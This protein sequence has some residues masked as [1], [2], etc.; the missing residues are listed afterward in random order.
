MPGGESRL[1]PP[2]CTRRRR[3]QSRPF[4]VRQIFAV[5]GL[6]RRS[7]VLAVFAASALAAVSARAADICESP[8]IRV[9]GKWKDPEGYTWAAP[10]QFESDGYQTELG[11]IETEGGYQMET[12]A[13][14]SCRGN[15]CE[16][17][18]GEIRVSIGYSSGRI[19]LN[20]DLKGNACHQVEVYLHELKHAAFWVEAENWGIAETRKRLTQALGVLVPVRTTRAGSE[21]TSSRFSREVQEITKRV[22]R[23]MDDWA[24]SRHRVLDSPENYARE[25][26]QANAQCGVLR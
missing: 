19:L 4:P 26:R 25:Q 1:L 18:P 6:L 12:K 8:S 24:E 21:A 14:I 13:A 23:E 15:R 17:C 9:E 20:P 16:V 2:I 22:Y 11:H 3:M 10:G 5:A 7:A